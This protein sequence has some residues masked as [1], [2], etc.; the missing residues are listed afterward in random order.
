MNKEKYARMTVV[1]DVETD[2]ALRC[3]ALLTERGVSE[4]VRELVSE[5]ALA[6]AE[7]L[8]GASFALS[9]DPNLSIDDTLDMFVEGAYGDYLRGRRHG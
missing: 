8:S 1:L 5:P 3:I 6:L 4:V 9:A 7:G 2:R